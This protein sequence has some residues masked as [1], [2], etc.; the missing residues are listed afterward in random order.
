M[1]CLRPGQAGPERGAALFLAILTLFIVTIMGIGLMFTTSIENTLAGTD[2]KVSKIFYAA[3]SGIEFGAARLR[4]DIN[5]VG[6]LMPGGVSSH[7]PGLSG[8]IQVTVARPII[9]GSRMH[10]GDMIVPQG[11]PYGT[12]QVTE[13][14][15]ALTSTA[16]AGATSIQ[17]SKTLDTDIGIYPQVMSIIPQ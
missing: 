17:A 8:D 1:T 10:P 13:M 3:D 9:I 6:G 4:T 7:Y 14:I 11:T 5:Y 12:P 15:F 16:T 2:T